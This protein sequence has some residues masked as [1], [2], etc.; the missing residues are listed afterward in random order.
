MNSQKAKETIGFLE[1][2]VLTLNEKHELRNKMTRQAI[3]FWV[4]LCCFL[5][6]VLLAFSV[7]H[8]VLLSFLLIFLSYYLGFVLLNL[9]DFN[10]RKYYYPTYKEFLEKITIEKKLKYEHFMMIEGLIYKDNKGRYYRMHHKYNMKGL[11]IE[12]EPIELL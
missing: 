11:Y 3:F 6:S 8:P 1:R 2:K 5:L 7:R 10:T 9:C 12:L 4:T